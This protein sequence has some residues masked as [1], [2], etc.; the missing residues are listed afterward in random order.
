MLH[1][2][3]IQRLRYRTSSYTNQREFKT[4]TTPQNPEW[5][6]PPSI[7]EQLGSLS[8]KPIKLLEVTMMLTGPKLP[9][10]KN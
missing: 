5:L 10:E 4:I 6:M 1:S 8:K 7:E 3:L 2:T 9:E